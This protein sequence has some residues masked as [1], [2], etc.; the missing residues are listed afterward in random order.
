MGRVEIRFVGSGD[1]FGSGGRFQTCIAIRTPEDLFLIDC[2]AS[3]LVA[4]RQQQL[5]P[6]DV[7]KIFITHLHGDHFGGVPFF[8]LDAQFASKR[9]APL[10]IAGP[11]GLVERLEQARE[12]LFPGSSKINPGFEIRLVELKPRSPASLDGVQVTAFPAAHFSGAPS[13]SLRVE[14]EGKTFV[15]S[16]DTQWTDTLIEASAGADLFACECYAFD[17]D[18]PLHNNYASIMENRSR[19]TCKRII[20]TH[21][22]EG[23]LS[24]VPEIELEAAED[25]MTVVL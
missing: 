7:S 18:V 20:V 12:V 9:E 17:K 14:V 13:Y 4:M 3:S 5:R 8:L 6:R 1:A 15:Y 2:G 16:G 24:R 21:M 23:M 19:M 11:P 22:N 25:G 10:T